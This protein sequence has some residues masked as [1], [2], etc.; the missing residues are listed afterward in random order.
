MAR[1][2]A[3]DSPGQENGKTG[4]GYGNWKF[5][6]HQMSRDEKEQLREWNLDLET[7]G[8]MLDRLVDSDIKLS[9]ALDAYNK[10]VTASLACR[11]QT[12]EDVNLILTGRAQS[13]YDAI[14]V[15]L[16]KHYVLLTD[17]WLAWQEK[18]GDDDILG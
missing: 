18:E 10:C 5:V 13:A 15:V 17:G 3:A 1:K 11:L 6:R 14:R 9:V 12:S 7:L 16:Y 8:Q 4:G 2:K